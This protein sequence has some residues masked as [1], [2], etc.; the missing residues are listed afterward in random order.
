MNNEPIIETCPI[1]LLGSNVYLI[2]TVP[3]GE[4]VIV[5][6]GL[7]DITVLRETLRTKRL[8]LQFI[9]NTHGHFDHV[10]GDGLLMDSGVSLA[11]HQADRDL[12]LQ[13]GGGIQFGFHIPPAPQPDRYLED[14]DEV[15]VD[16]AV[17]QVLHTPGHTRGS[18]CLYNRD[19]H[20]LLSGDTLFAG[21]VGRTDLPGG[22]PHALKRSLKRLI[23]LPAPTKV[24]PGHGPATT[25]ADELRTNPWLRKLNALSRGKS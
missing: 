13:G 17:F 19:A 5:D 4:A 6:P 18:L 11:I 14:G 12:L 10:A 23:S 1:G 8:H 16:E 20:I 3:N 24:Y 9:I 15:Q 22:N 2:Y 7:R 21:G 25:I